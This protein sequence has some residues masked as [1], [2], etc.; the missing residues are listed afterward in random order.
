MINLAEDL[1]VNKYKI[2]H[3]VFELYNMKYLLRK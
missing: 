1:L 2:K 3:N